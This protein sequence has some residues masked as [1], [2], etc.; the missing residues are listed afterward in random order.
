MS[1]TTP[2]TIIYLTRHGETDSNLHEI[3]HGSTD[4]PLN[5]TGVRQAKEVKIELKD[6]VFDAGYSSDLSRARQTAALVLDGRKLKITVEPGLRERGFG[7]Y[8]GMPHDQY[9]A[10][11]NEDKDKNTESNAAVLARAM[12]ALREIAETHQHQTVFIASHGALIKNVLSEIM[13]IPMSDLKVENLG[14]A[15]LIYNNGDWTVAD[16][17]RIKILSPVIAR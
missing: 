13:N 8:E 1:F 2:T 10:L 6:I 9:Y 4:V 15:K 5:T 14:Y 16:T 7:C 11:S 12:I 3:V 17:K